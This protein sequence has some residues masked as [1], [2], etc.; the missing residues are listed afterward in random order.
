MV[1]QSFLAE[2]FEVGGRILM[3]EVTALGHH[4]QVTKAAD[5][6]MELL[7]LL[8]HHVR[9]SRRNQSCVDEI[10]HAG[11]CHVYALPGSKLRFSKSRIIRMDSLAERATPKRHA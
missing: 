3:T 4:K 1:R 5:V 2:E 11:F 7:D 8:E 10:V 6:I 9:R